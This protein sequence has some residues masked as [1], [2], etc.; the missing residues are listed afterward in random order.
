MRALDI[1]LFRDL[2]RLWTQVLAISLV[3]A[4]GVATLLMAVGSYRSLEETR[5]AYYERYFFA[6]V[7]ATVRRAPKSVLSQIALIPG[8]AAV[9]GRIA[10]LA[11]LDIP[12]YSA[13]ATG[14]FVSLPESG[15][16]SLNR[17]YMRL[18]NMPESGRTDQVLV[19]ESFAKAHRLSPGSRFSAVLNGRKRELTI[20]GVA[21]SPEFIYA[22]GPGDLMPD[23]SRFGIIWMP[24][25]ALSGAYDLE[26]AFSS[27]AVKLMRNAQEREVMLRI[28]ALLERY[29]GRAAYGRKDQT[30]HA[31]LDHEL[32]M[33]G[34]MSRTLPPIFL[35]VSAYL[36]NLTLG[37]L[38]ALEREQIG[39]LKAVGY[40]SRQVIAHYLKF[41]TVIVAIGVVIGS[42][43]G[44]LLGATITQ[45]FGD[46]FHFP[47]LVFDKSA[48]LYVLAA[49]LS[50]LTATLG[51]VRSL[52][53]VAR[54]PPAVAM[55][56]PTPRRFRKLLP[57]GWGRGVLPQS[58]RIMIRNVA[59]HPIRAAFTMLGISLSTAILIVSLFTRDTMEQLVEVIYFQ[60]DRQ[61]ATVSFVERRPLETVM[62]VAR[63]PGVLAAEPR[64]EVP[65]RI[66]N[67]SIERRITVNAY[68]ESPDLSRVIDVNLRPVAL[69]ETGIA[70]SSMLAKI[71]GVGVGESV[72]ID[73][74]EGERRTVAL[75]VTA[76]VEDYFG[77]RGMTS[78]ASLARI[79]REA[80]SISAV[81]VSLDP[82]WQQQFF[83]AI[84]LT[85][86]I[87]A[88]ALQ[89]RSLETFRQVIALLI[90][91]MA[92]IYTVLA[93]CI[94]CGVV[95]NGA[96][97]SLSERARE[98]ASLRVLGFTQQE[99][100]RILLLELAVL[101]LAAQPLGWVLG[102]GLAAIMQANLAG[103]IMRVRL[104]VADQ[105][106][107][108]A[109]GIVLAA[110]IASAAVIRARVN[111]LDLVAVLKTRD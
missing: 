3:V 92:G 90:T 53:E 26:G 91:T 24:E 48:D 9:E 36:V 66:R 15:T 65:A 85:P 64:R 10:K 32:D 59:S 19:N 30:S 60:A 100:F 63:M 23:D 95:Y 41:V 81:N 14:Q 38:V 82:I 98:L 68:P 55:Q 37:R 108:L 51:A 18:G 80:P 1:K 12:G 58:T 25:K 45:L 62:Q 29:G 16:A 50:L 39:L 109:S 96:R 93:A 56:P 21:L 46:F 49:A 105:T 44:T 42:V 104:V 70:L 110:A 33:L 34:N 67:G 6:D 31:W 87:G 4:G 5:A 89:R 61:D 103:E 43:A 17:L 71:L 107:L 73:I 75:P 27:V 72:E 8:V 77:I 84:K 28:D 11:L 83:D 111:R 47:F 35:L 101:T 57:A 102:F 54:M 79:M 20:V 88:L 99:V 22:V 78:I 86:A 106:Y 97:V 74:L 2:R 52:I 40:R 76:L 94:A 13:P 69:P 7:F